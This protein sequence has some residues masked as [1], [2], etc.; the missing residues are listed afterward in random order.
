M[1]ERGPDSSHSGQIP[2]GELDPWSE[3]ATEWTLDHGAGGPMYDPPP[4]PESGVRLT[5]LLELDEDG[6]AAVTRD[7]QRWLG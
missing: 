3:R 5:G 2:S 7:L 4:P 6:V 1:S